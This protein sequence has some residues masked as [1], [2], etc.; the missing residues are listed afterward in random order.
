M[1]NPM[2]TFKSQYKKL[3]L[4]FVKYSPILQTILLWIYII[5]CLLGLRSRWVELTLSCS[6]L[7]FI[8]LISASVALD[9]CVLHRAFIVYNFITYLLIIIYGIY[10]NLLFLVF[11]RY[12]MLFIG[13]FLFIILYIK[14]HNNK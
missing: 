12:I 10:G 13:F 5:L 1:I 4:L 7:S 14:I 9:F 3:C 8:R 6:L 2:N 11:M